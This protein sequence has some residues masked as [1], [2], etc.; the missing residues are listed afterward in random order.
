MNSSKKQKTEYEKYMEEAHNRI[1]LP[2][3][4]LAK[5]VEDAVGSPIVKRS[6]I[7]KGE[8]NQV[9][10]VTVK[11]GHKVIVRVSKSDSR[12]FL[13]EKWAIEECEKVGVP[14]PEILL[15]KHLKTSEGY[16]SVCIQ[17]K[18]DGDTLER[19]G[20]D[21]DAMAEIDLRNLIMQAGEILSKIHNVKTKG[22]GRIDVEGKG[23]LKNFEELVT[24]AVM[25]KDSCL[26]LAAKLDIDLKV[27]RE[28][29]NLVSTRAKDY[30]DLVPV[31]NHGDYGPKHLMIKDNK[32]VGV[33]DFGE[34]RSDCAIYDFAWW[35][36]WFNDISWGRN[37]K[38]FEWLKEGYPDKS[39]FNSDFDL[40]L[41][42]IE[43][44]LALGSL[45]WYD[46]GGYKE[47][48]EYAKIRL[49]KAYNFFK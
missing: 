18:I 23:S 45:Y 38:L 3:E 30:R 28:I 32:I 44:N 8:A 35:H 33:L 37:G 26:K 19:G 10:D 46:L 20:I 29:I 40:I 39:I 2:D 17:K 5:A 15:I 31:L 47:G 41:H 13:Q 12:Q 7:L 27:M 42:L 43:V 21:M 36:S 14:I 48:I 9:F 16:Y 11:N 22:F 24:E 1:S 25:K 34:V 4:I 49:L 6:K